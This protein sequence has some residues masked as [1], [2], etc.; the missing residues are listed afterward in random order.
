ML[1]IQLMFIDSFLKP[2]V[3]SLPPFVQ[4]WDLINTLQSV[5]LP[6]NNVL[7]WNRCILTSYNDGGIQAVNFYFNDY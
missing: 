7:L 4:D 2:Y 3:Q 5:K 6:H 1:I